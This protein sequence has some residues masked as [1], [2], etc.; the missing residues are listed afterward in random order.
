AKRKKRNEGADVSANSPTIAIPTKT[1]IDIARDWVAADRNR[2]AVQTHI[3]HMNR[4]AREM[5][6]V[7][8]STPPR[9]KLIVMNGASPAKN[10]T[11]FTH[12]VMILPS[13]ISRGESVVWVIRSRV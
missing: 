9:R 8:R 10:R 6:I 5:R 4:M 11:S 12:C 13:T 1:T 3:D 7:V 2:H